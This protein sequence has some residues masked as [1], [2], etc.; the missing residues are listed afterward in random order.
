[1]L[2]SVVAGIKVLYELG[3]VHRDI[4]PANILV[5][6][7]SDGS[8]RLLLTD[9]GFTTR[10]DDLGNFVC[11]T[12]RFI[13]PEMG[14][15]G[16]P[17]DLTDIWSLG[18]TLYNILVGSV[19]HVPDKVEPGVLFLTLPHKARGEVTDSCWRLVRRMLT[20]DPRYRIKYQELFDDP[21]LNA[22]EED[23]DNAY[24]ADRKACCDSLYAKFPSFTRKCIPQDELE[25]LLE[26]DTS[27]R[28]AHHYRPSTPPASGEKA[29]GSAK[30]DVANDQASNTFHMFYDA[31]LVFAQ[32][33]A[34]CE[35]ISAPMAISHY[36]I[37][38]TY[39]SLIPLSFFF[40][41]ESL[42]AAISAR[43]KKLEIDLFKTSTGAAF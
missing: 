21:W 6:R 19:Y 11:G 7:N 25:K 32:K 24:L 36:N 4:K 22:T 30:I 28:R 27:T 41:A 20:V 42:L 37:A 15:R 2:F 35:M 3:Y 43:M 26:Q 23:L 13:A 9:F 1:M 14:E 34:A 18:V 39:L 33:G 31:A 38:V 12:P 16:K 17:Q 10:K 29:E 5:K 8:M 40:K